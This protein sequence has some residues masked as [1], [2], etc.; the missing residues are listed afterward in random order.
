MRYVS[1]STTPRAAATTNPRGVEP[2]P[3]HN[4]A[5]GHS[6][7][8]RG[9]RCR[10]TPHLSARRTILDYR[11]QRTP[12][13]H[14]ELNYMVQYRP[15]ATLSAPTAVQQLKNNKTIYKEKKQHRR[16]LLAPRLPQLYTFVYISELV[17]R[18]RTALGIEYVRGMYLVG[19]EP[20][21]I[22]WEFDIFHGIWLG[23]NNGI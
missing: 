16:Q 3:S 9:L 8:S 19:W 22:V 2:R 5:A 20:K 21:A 4:N 13:M 18:S 14:I 1:E 17:L 15:Y 23:G 7:P 10:W 11:R 12:R 6:K